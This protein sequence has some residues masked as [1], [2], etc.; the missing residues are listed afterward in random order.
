MDAGSG[1]PDAS[2]RAAH[3]QP[4][5]LEPGERSLAA[6]A[7][8]R[9]LL[10][11]QQRRQD[12]PARPPIRVLEARLRRPARPLARAPRTRAATGHSPQRGARG[13]QTVAPSSIIAWLNAAARPA[14]EQ[15]GGRDAS[16]RG[17]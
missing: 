7:V 12:A 14:R 9:R 5:A 2:I 11:G 13:R 8:D 10:A 6:R 16:A 4:V 15:L 3:D 17:V 1:Q